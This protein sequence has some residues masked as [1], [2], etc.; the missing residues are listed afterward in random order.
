MLDEEPQDGV[1]V[2]A[3]DLGGIDAA[4]RT[5]RSQS[6]RDAWMADL[7]DAALRLRRP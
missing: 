2:D 7:H 5:H 4:W 3:A 1:G 6:E